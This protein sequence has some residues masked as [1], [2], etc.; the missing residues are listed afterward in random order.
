MSFLT[1]NVSHI[2][3]T[4]PLY[5]KK[6]IKRATAIITAKRIAN[7]G[8]KTK[9]LPNTIYTNEIPVI[10]I[11]KPIRLIDL[12]IGILVYLVGLP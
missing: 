5:I 6:K 1:K 4:S 7:H 3:K 9:N 11:S 10:K 8:N 2:I 12:K